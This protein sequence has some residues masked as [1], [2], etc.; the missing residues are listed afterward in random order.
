MAVDLARP[1]HVYWSGHAVFV[2]RPEDSPIYAQAFAGFW[3]CH[4]VDV[5]NVVVG[6]L[7]R[8]STTTTRRPSTTASSEHA[9]EVHDNA[10]TL[11]HSA[12]EVL[13]DKDFASC[14]P[15]SSPSPICL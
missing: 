6:R 8:R 13:R 10:V 7:P 1:D 5:T 11:R 12:S 14:S 9:L 4:D 15:K 3:S 2:R